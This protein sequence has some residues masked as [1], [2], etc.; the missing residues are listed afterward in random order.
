MAG[1][2]LTG[3]WNEHRECHV[4]GDFLLVYNVDDS[5]KYGLVVF[6]RAGTKPTCST[7]REP[8]PPVF[9]GRTP[10]TRTFALARSRPPGHSP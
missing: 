7:S 8:A 1:P 2:P 4:G 3:E 10:L 9:A 5:G 6:V